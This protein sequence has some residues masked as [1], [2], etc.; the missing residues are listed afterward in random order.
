MSLNDK[1]H[2]RYSRHL[3]LDKVG[4][5]GQLKLKKA[6]VLIVGTGGLGC[7][8][9]MYLTAAGVGHIG[10]IDFDTIDESNLQRQILIDSCDIGKSKVLTA[11]RKLEAQNPLINIMAYNQILNNQNAIDLFNPLRWICNPA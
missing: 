10:I 8:I 9:L 4:L 1:E 6:K 7:P 5:E 11:K 2:N 3:L